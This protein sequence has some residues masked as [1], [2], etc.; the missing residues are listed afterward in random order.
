ML[1]HIPRVL[2]SVYQKAWILFSLIWSP[3]NNKLVFSIKIFFLTTVS[4]RST[5]IL[6]CVILDEKREIPIVFINK[7]LV[8]VSEIKNQYNLSIQI[9]FSLL[10]KIINFI[11]I[12]NFN[13]INFLIS[14]AGK[15]TEFFKLNIVNE[16]TGALA[17]PFCYCL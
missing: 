14:K 15:S 5:K 10:K 11:A 17:T 16:V 8:W 13:F 1:T 9:C 4:I 6:T 3:L 12:E 2:P 7:F